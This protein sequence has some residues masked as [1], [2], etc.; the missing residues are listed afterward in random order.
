MNRMRSLLF[1]SFVF[2]LM[3]NSA[4]AA[5]PDSEKL[6]GFKRGIVAVL[7]LENGN[8]DF[9]MEL[10]K[11][12]GVTVYFQSN[13]AGEIATVRKAA[14]KAKLLGTRIFVGTGSLK[15]VQ[16]GN[17]VADGAIVV[18]TQVKNSSKSELLRVLRPQAKAYF[19]KMTFTKPIPK[20]IDEWT[21]P[22]HK[23]DNNPQSTDQLA[24]G[25]FRT[26]FIADPKFSPMPEQ[27][28]VA[29][30]RMYKAM[31]HI[32]HKANQNAMLN[33]LLCINAYNGT[34]LWERPL[35]KGFMI[36]RN[37]MIATADALYMGD[38][39]SC[40]VFDAK[41]G[42]IRTEI[43]VPKKITDGPVWKWMG[44]QGDTL[45]ALVG[46]TEVK[47]DTR[48]SARRGLGHWPWGMWK[49]HDYSDPRMAFGFG[50]TLVAIDLKTNKIRWHHREKKD[51]L[52]ARAL[53]LK[54]DKIFVYTP[55]KQITCLSTENG[56]VLWK[57]SDKNLLA[58][59]GPNE[60]AQHY[61]TGYATACYMKCNENS[62]FFSGPQRKKLVVASTKDGKLQWTHPVGN[63]Q[64]VLRKDALY[65]AGPQRS[66][67]VCLDYT[68]GKTLSTF[69][70]RRACTRATGS[71]DSLFF[72]ASGGTVRLMTDTK[73]EQHIAPMRP[74]CQDGVIISNGNLYWGPWMCGCQLSLYGNIACR[75][76]VKEDT[77][78]PKEIYKNALVTFDNFENVASL[79][80]K[81]GDWTAYRG[82]NSRN[83]VT[84]VSLP[85]DVKLQWK[86]TVSAG[87]LPTAPVTAGGMVFVADRTGVV[88][89]LN[90]SGKLVWKAYT[91][92][93]IY[94]SP[95]IAHDRVYVGSADGRV[96]AFEAKTG[97]PLWNYRVAPQDRRIPV[98][99]KLISRWPVAGGVAIEG[100]TLYAAAGIAHYDGTYIVALD[101][102]TG[103]LKAQNS[104]SGELSAR[105]NSGIS[106]QGNLKIANGELQFLGGGVYETARYNLKSLKCLNTPH[107]Q[108]TSRYRTAFYPFYPGYGKYISLSYKC[109]DGCQLNHDASYEGSIFSNLALER[110]LPK[111]AKKLKKDAA[112]DFLRS[113][114]RRGKVPPKHVWRDDANRRFTGF[115]V[116]NG[117]LLA[118][119]H[120]DTHK[121]S[122]FISTLTIK[123]GKTVWRKPLPAL[124]V[125]GGMAVDHQGRIFVT[126]EN[127]QL[128]C[129]AAEKK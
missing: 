120:I 14:E 69:V 23:P 122:A 16:L 13:D 5:A 4:I 124:P 125:K 21:H 126:L 90:E 43:T 53:C 18:S 74:P 57:N 98:Y 112:N 35:P 32:A 34:I 121:N 113:L 94:Y 38:D 91:G 82:A 41:T 6:F 114:R 45:F 75:G 44:Q 54:G 88:R 71:V 1:A 105:A 37:T 104:N 47:V 50:R 79:G 46:S 73:Y 27:T 93:A 26:Q 70:A 56:K 15:T 102:K 63:L 12:P 117:R 7:G 103:K 83:D 95:A 66:K 118:A 80:A 84:S 62:L 100:D 68:S 85:G 101:A 22:Y 127:G 48:K 25:K 49:G 116:S 92:G 33:T 2:A 29:G 96:Y 110:P 97:R 129:F 9:I 10:A 81:P 78:N 11:P 87:D 76:E 107:E 42:K 86:A 119:G 99:G 111:G 59:I 51:F 19:G 24:I 40:K 123:D 31:G 115:A 89:A 20:G 17:N 67:G 64:I 36:H 58:A 28:V 3:G 72:R 77:L 39:K 55:Q 8:A 30:G 65:A 61:V 52:D 109:T 106:I 128:L 108:P 60:K